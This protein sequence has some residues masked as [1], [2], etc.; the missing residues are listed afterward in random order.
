MKWGFMVYL[1][2]EM[3]LKDVKYHVEWKNLTILFPRNIIVDCRNRGNTINLYPKDGEIWTLNS[4]NETD[5][6]S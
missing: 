2:K 6:V 1:L 5:S 3:D 4:L